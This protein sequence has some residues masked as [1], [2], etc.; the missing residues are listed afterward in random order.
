[1]SP[2]RPLIGITTYHRDRG[3][4]ERFH[5]P[6]AYVDAVRL[7]G[8]LPVLLPPGDA[9]PDEILDSIDGLLLCGGGDIDPARFGG[10]DGHEAQYATCSERDGFE[11][12]LAREA[13]ER[14]MPLLAICR[15]LQVLN[16]LR[17]GDLHVHLP[18]VVGVRV[19]HRLAQDRHTM[20]PVR[21]EP[22]SRLAAVLGT[23]AV[24][25]A[26]WHHQAVDRLGEGLRAVAW[27]EDGT[28]EAVEL[29]DHPEVLSVQ[30]H[31]ELQVADGG[32]P[33]RR[34]F[35]TLVQRA[36][37]RIDEARRPLPRNP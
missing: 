24:E 9:R 33:H 30:W 21:I 37:E 19:I 16:V 8:G 23:S 29:A 1:M 15:G 3:E 7:E 20:H 31:P 17:G 2:R 22:A 13:L 10:R 14:R 18:D 28:I 4:R 5:V 25:V 36:G 12:A 32:S 35:R 27:A 34:L 6:A 26:S 11:L